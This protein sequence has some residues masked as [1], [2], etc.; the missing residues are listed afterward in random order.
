M[1]A[2]DAAVQ[3][4]VSPSKRKGTPI[5]E[6]TAA[7]AQ[8]LLNGMQCSADNRALR[9]ARSVRLV[10]LLDRDDE[11]DRNVAL[12]KALLFNWR[13]ERSK[14]A[15][16]IVARP[17]VASVCRSVM[18]SGHVGQALV[19]E[20][21]SDARTAALANSDPERILLLGLIHRVGASAFVR[22]ATAMDES[23]ATK[24]LL[25][26]ML[27]IAVA[28]CIRPLAKNGQFMSHDHVAWVCRSSCARLILNCLCAPNRPL[29]PNWPG[30]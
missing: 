24:A 3:S 28:L 27:G 19:R 11:L 25:S 22:E 9:F 10:S 23:L 6:T 14:R 17:I 18:S 20:F 21:C 15:A 30:G 5:I 26:P 29:L 13:K 12:S 8:Q 2:A 7:G 16:A 4:N 1:A